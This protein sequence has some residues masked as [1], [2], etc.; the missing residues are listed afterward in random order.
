[1]KLFPQLTHG[2]GNGVDRACLMTAS[3]M[4][5]GRGEDGDKNHCV[6]DV[7]RAFVIVTND[8]MP[9]H[10]LGPLYGPLTIE[11]LGT[12][13]N[14]PS[15][16]V[17]RAMA[18]ADWAVR[19]IA[20]LALEAS[21]R[22]SLAKQLRSLAPVCDQKTAIVAHTVAAVVASDS[23]SRFVGYAAKSAS[24]AASAAYISAASYAAHLASAVLTSSVWDKC[25]EIIRRVAAIG[26]QRPVERVI[27]QRD[28]VHRL[29][30]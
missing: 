4:L 9:E 30:A 18:F 7:I 20:P 10:L 1:M 6:C 23:N 24:N 27:S 26:D 22:L 5:I 19:E 25:P 16:L 8:A 2:E 13:T 15:V 12:R 29:G 11:I 17:A 28:L 3:N 14:D 21:G